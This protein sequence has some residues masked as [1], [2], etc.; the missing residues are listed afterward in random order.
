MS[1]KNYHATKL[2]SVTVCNDKH[3]VR[4]H[5]GSY[6]DEETAKRVVTNLG[7]LTSPKTG[8]SKW[9]LDKTCSNIQL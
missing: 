1:R 7:Y 9:I 8:K 3:T 4:N 2:Y 6:A 5:I